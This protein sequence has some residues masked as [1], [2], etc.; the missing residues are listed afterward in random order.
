M[1]KTL[2]LFIS[3]LSFIVIII[4]GIIFVLEVRTASVPKRFEEILSKNIKSQVDIYTNKQGIPHIIAANDEDMF[5]AMGYFHARE[6]L[7]SMC[8]SKIIAEGRAAEFYGE[9]FFQLDLYMRTLN[10]A[11]IANQ[12]YE[13]ANEETKNVLIAYSNGINA[14]VENNINRLT[15]E[16]AASDFLPEK[17]KP[18][19]CFLI[20]RYMAFLLNPNFLSDIIFAEIAQKIGVEKTID[21]VPNY[22]NNSPHILDENFNPFID[23]P[24]PELDALKKTQT[25]DFSQYDNFLQHSN[26]NNNNNNIPLYGEI[27]Q[28][29]NISQYNKFQQNSKNNALLYG[30]NSH[31]SNILQCNKF[32]QNSKNNALLYAK[33][34][35]HS[36]ISQC[37]KFQQNSNNNILLYGEIPQHSN[38][39]QYNKFQQNSK[40]NTLLY[41]ENSHHSN[42]PQCNK[43]Q[44]NSKNNPPLCDKIPQHA[45]IASYILA[46]QTLLGKEGSNLGSNTWATNKDNVILAND[47]HLP[48]TIPCIWIQMHISSPNYNVIGLSI[49]GMPIFPCGRNDHIAW[50]SANMLVDD[51]DYLIQ[52]LDDEQSF[53]Y[54]DGATRKA[55]SEEI[56]TIKIR[57]KT[58]TAQMET[59]LYYKRSIDDCAIISEKTI[60]DYYEKNHSNALPKKNVSTGMTMTYKWTGQHLSNEIDVMLR[61][62]RASNWDSFLAAVNDWHCPG[63]VF[64][65]ADKDG[66]IGLAP[67]ALIPVRAKDVIPFLPYP[68]W[69]NNKI[70]VD[71]IAP[72]AL[73]VLF[74]PRKNFVAASNNALFRNNTLY[75][76]SSFA[77]NSRAKRIE[78]MLRTG[79]N[80]SRRDAQY[81]QNDILCNYAKDYLSKI[82][83]IF[84]KHEHLLTVEEKKAYYKLVKWDF[85]L[86]PNSTTASIYNM[87]ISKIA[88]N[89]FADELGELY[90]FYIFNSNF[91]LAKLIELLNEPLSQ[92]FDNVGTNEREH[93][94]FIVIN[95]FK[96]AMAELGNLYGTG[97]SDRWKYSLHHR[98]NFRHSFNM[99]SFLDKATNIGSFEV[100]GG[101]STINCTEWKLNKPFDVVLGTSMRF[102]ADMN[103]DIIYTIIPGGTS[104]D[105]MNPNYSDQVQL[106]Q[107]GTYVK[108]SISPFP[109]SDF[110]LVLSIKRGD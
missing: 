37:N 13:N 82:L 8:H 63:F 28:H 86:S 106:W 76:S 36:N 74:N 107:I 98:V 15:F 97:N 59:Y 14:F 94:E 95:S 25:I 44:Q 87:L 29:S 100:G 32:Q 7:W 85:M 61:V 58:R 43:F 80:Y 10:L 91:A 47:S 18:S 49:P 75:I 11:K 88:R 41:G 110:K 77:L 45:G 71:Y 46:M 92:W 90:D 66:N 84:K 30:E 17:W 3:I 102:I 83:F 42:I 27:P 65:Y 105:P 53:Y 62:M 64:S 51:V 103:Q 68:F 2:K 20:Q 34:S 24:T 6:R 9:N 33:N 69:K 4:V 40:N 104:G 54:V 99:F 39:S 16:F 108:L 67:R 57:S 48:L 93:F 5:F 19:D 38:I 56:D 81:M 79:E 21:L 50:G 23:N 31:H 26:R 72:S 78:E 12:L 60:F 35:Q 73:P 52:K 55:I 70:W 89:T 101:I 1:K 96:E 22:P 109:A